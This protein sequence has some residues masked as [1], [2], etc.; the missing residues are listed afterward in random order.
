[1]K[2]GE[3]AFRQQSRSGSSLGRPFP[4]LRVPFPG[5]PERDRVLLRCLLEMAEGLDKPGLRE[6]VTRFLVESIQAMARGTME[7]LLD[8]EYAKNTGPS[9]LMPESD[10]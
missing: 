7:S 8:L 3:P 2:S 5:G 1:M 6:E 9:G 4:D 10:P